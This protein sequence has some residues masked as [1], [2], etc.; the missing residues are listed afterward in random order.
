MSSV[1]GRKFVISLRVPKGLN[2]F[3]MSPALAE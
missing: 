1:V 3:R 2:G